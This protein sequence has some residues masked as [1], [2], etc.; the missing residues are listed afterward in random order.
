MQRPDRRP[1]Q[2]D[3]TTPLEHA[4]DDGL[5]EVL[6][7]QDAAPAFKGLIGGE[8]HGASAPVPLVDDMEEH[9]GG[10]GPVRE[11]ADLIDD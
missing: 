8:D 10:I 2:S 11:I 3:Q 9:V 7:V 6:V 1:V 4:I 5:G